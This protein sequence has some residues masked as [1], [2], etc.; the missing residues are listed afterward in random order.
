VN[1]AVLAATRA[2][3]AE[4]GYQ[5]TSIQAIARSAEVSVPAIYR[6]WETKEALVED[7]VFGIDGKWPGPPSGDLYPDLLG[8]VRAFLGAAADPAGR[9]GLPGLI[10]AYLHDAD[11]YDRLARRGE[12]PAREGLRAVV[13]AAA[14][15]GG[16]HPDCD[17]ET[18][19]DLLR[20]VTMLRGLMQGQ[21]DADAFCQR[22][23]HMLCDAAQHPAA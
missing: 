11:A 9:S 8:W 17:V 4:V 15:N 22:V 13:D 12:M 5:K 6:R 10:S 21:D 7:A 14:A 2:L 20:G 3:L 1:D 19:F 23:A 18:L 16:A